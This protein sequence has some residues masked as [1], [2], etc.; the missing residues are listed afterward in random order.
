MLF[1]F[2]I[3]WAGKPQYQEKMLSRPETGW[4]TITE[5]RCGKNKI[6]KARVWDLSLALPLHLSL[7][8]L[9]TSTAH[10][11]RFLYQGDVVQ[12]LLPL[13]SFH[14]WRCRFPSLELI[15]ALCQWEPPR[16]PWCLSRGCYSSPSC[17]KLGTT[18]QDHQKPG[19]GHCPKKD[20]LII[21]GVLCWSSFPPSLGYPGNL[22]QL[23][24]NQ[25]ELNRVLPPHKPWLHPPL[26]SFPSASCPFFWVLFFV[27]PKLFKLLI[28]R[29][30]TSRKLGQNANIELKKKVLQSEHPYN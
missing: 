4:R 19:M 28:V 22:R 10:T 26:P 14:L 3:L 27:T 25:G 15:Y 30:N 9:P 18:K 24:P 29:C 5:G 11:S 12:Q 1:T 2:N 20:R 13:I 21:A 23:G 16:A 6:T 17:R 8:V 7:L